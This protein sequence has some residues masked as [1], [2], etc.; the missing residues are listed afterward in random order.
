MLA[1]AAP[2]FVL[3]QGLIIGLGYGLLAV[4][5]VLIYR[6]N[7][8]LNFAQGQ[9]GVI[10]AVFLVK[11]TADFKF[12]Y[13]FA[14]VLSIALA[15]AV[16]ALSELVLRRLFS[17]PRVLVM[18]ATIGLSQVLLA[19]TALP[20]IR[21]HNLYK[22][23]PVPFDISFTLGTTIFTP[24]EVL[25]LIVAPIVALALAFAVRT[26]TWGLSMRAM[27][28]NA[29]SARL[30]GVWIRRTSTLTWTVAGALSAFTAILN[31]PGQTSAL[32]QVLSPDLLLFALTAALVGAMINLTVAFVAGIGVGVLYEL[33]QWNISSTANQQLVLFIVLLVVLVIR[34]RALRKDSRS[35]E[36][37]TWQHGATTAR[38][39]VDALRHRVSVSGTWVAVV[40]AVA[41]PLVLSVGNNYLFSQVCIYAVIALSL[42]ILTG[43]AGQVSLGQF[44][45]AAVGALVAAHLG[46]SFPLPL[47]LAFAGVVT[48]LVAIVVGLPALRMP[49]LFLAVTT[50]AFAIFM[51][52]AVLATPCWTV[53]GIHKTLCTGLPNPASTLIGRPTLLG[54]SLQSQR[55]FAWFSLGVL[56]LS[57][58]AVR[59]WRD[60]GVARRL[61]AVRDNELGAAAMGIPVLR[62]KLL[63]FGLSGFMAGYAGA[64]LAFSTQR[65]ST[66]TFDPTISFT[67]I[68]MVV[69]GGL[70]SIPG[71][72]LGALYLEG[73]PSLFGSNATIQFLTSGLGL[74]A[75]ILYLPGG[76]GELLRR[77]G[78]VVTVGL[79]AMQDRLSTAP[80]RCVT[81]RG[82]IGFRGGRHA[83]PPGRATGA[84]GPRLVSELTGPARLTVENLGVTFGGI[85]AV[86]DVSFTAEPGAIVGLIGANGSGKTTT[87]DVVSGLVV[88]QRG[89]VRLDGMDLAEYLPEER[90]RVGMVRSF[91]D[92]RL[93]PELSVLDVLL[94]C[95]DVKHEVAVLPTTLRLP[96]ARRSE[97]KKQAAVDQVIGAFGL[98]RFRH[99]RTAELSTGTRR[100]VDLA[101]IFLAVAPPAP[102]RRAHG[103]H[104]P[105]RSR[106]VHPAAAATPPDR[107]H[108]HRPRRTR[109]PAGLRALFPRGG[110]GAGTGG[111]RWTIRRGARRPQSPGGVSWRQRRG[112]RGV[113]TE[114]G[115]HRRDAGRWTGG[116]G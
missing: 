114:R 49:G 46:G 81:A 98:E 55:S 37:S 59:V 94:L 85:R 64:C 47:L 89:T 32:T 13:W 105:A 1:F 26:T 23:V 70:G 69:I 60:K 103:R 11:L 95:E 44:A 21:P 73:L 107:R 39:T 113:R 48:A 8:V 27:S 10:A 61:V 12:E 16:G 91:Q 109:R 58:L 77:F 18:V 7:R 30:S 62:T 83:R 79:R 68:S 40:G 87:L 53:P 24:A 41:L 84:R 29:D 4:G 111:G 14:L 56:V 22:P 19:L 52:E 75:F 99:H 2:N 34:A 78:D 36:R 97:K 93:F 54:L 66:E 31:A 112:T 101:S 115:A 63:A 104:R 15:A 82:G 100:V 50:L 38:A 45:L 3:L 57:I 9:V 71:A 110:H 90:Q 5:L 43:W 51:Q 106:G 72:V 65:F 96:W 74:I 33:L 6:T 35:G 67:I 76:L 108:H 92:C 86:D 80:S 20:F 116:S 42:T 28:E 25:T 17:R 102:A 88:P